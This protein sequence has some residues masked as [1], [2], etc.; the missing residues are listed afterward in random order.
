MKKDVLDMGESTQNKNNKPKPTASEKRQAQAQKV[1][2][3][4]KKFRRNVTL[5]AAVLVVLL[6]VSVLINSNYLKKGVPAAKIGSWSFSATDVN[7]YYYTEYY[8]LYTQYGDY[9]SYFLDTSK[10]LD[11]QQFS[12]TQTWADYLQET[13]L[14]NMQET[15]IL[16][17]AAKKAGYKLPDEAK[18]AIDELLESYRTTYKQQ[19]FASVTALL[20]A[21]YGEGTTESNLKKNLEIQYLAYYYAKE[22]TDAL[23]FTDDE[24]S[25]YYAKNKDSKDVF[26]YRE[27][28][29]SGA[30]DEVNGIDSTKAMANAKTIAEK[31]AAAKTESEFNSLVYANAPE[32][33]KATY[34]NGAGTLKKYQSSSSFTSGTSEWLLDSSRKSGNTTVVETTDGYFVLYF[35]ERN[36]N[37]YNVKNVRHILFKVEDKTNADQY[38]EALTKAQ[39]VYD[40]WKKGAATEDSFAELAKTN[41][42]DSNASEGGFYAV[43][44]G[45]MVSEFEDWCFAANRKAGDSGIVKTDYGYHIMYY[46]GEGELYWKSLATT[47][48]KNDTYTKMVSDQ[49]GSYEISKTFAMKFT[50]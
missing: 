19:D 26:T 21:K 45:Q 24:L 11:Q 38:A 7:F 41:S 47:G 23:K 40:E 30:A 50:K 16:N 27:Y 6:A 43:N 12:D 33:E 49:K 18:N 28:K 39:A 10:P 32:A 44:K 25:A 15:C 13:A 4:K 1:L 42:A 35:I 9:L 17:D 22:Y 48:L 37:S 2:Q 14:N 36:D 20:E 34:E 31:I 5:I 3:E 8:N 29:V 46:S